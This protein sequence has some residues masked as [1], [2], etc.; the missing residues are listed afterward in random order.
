MTGVAAASRIRVEVS[1]DPRFARRVRRLTLVSAVALGVIWSLAIGTL[2]A[3]PL[4]GAALAAGWLLM[5]LILAASLRR[6][7]LRYGL[8]LPAS[9]VTLALLAVCVGWLPA[10]PLAA[11]GWVLM[12]AGIALGGSLGLWLWYRLL[13]VPAALDDPFAGARW[14]LIGFHVTLVVVGAALAALAL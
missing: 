7:W 1:P 5:P 2:E 9:L 4:V 11:V 13:P 6:P 3:P 14:G 10:P 8:T 12:T